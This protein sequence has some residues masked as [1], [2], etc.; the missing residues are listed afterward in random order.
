MPIDLNSPAAL[1]AELRAELEAVR[2]NLGSLQAIQRPVMY[3]P[4]DSAMD[5]LIDAVTKLR[6]YH[7]TITFDRAFE[8]ALEL[9]RLGQHRQL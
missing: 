1:G 9:K 7:P 3:Q 4:L 5:E 6:G 2:G 8:I